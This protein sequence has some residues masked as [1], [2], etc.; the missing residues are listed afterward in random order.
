MRDVARSHPVPKSPRASPSALQAEDQRLG[1]RVQG[2]PELLQPGSGPGR[3]QEGL[4]CGGRT[5]HAPHAA[6][7]SERL[8]LA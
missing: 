3:A 4:Q 7:R 6:V 1:R 2:P 8:Q 5:V